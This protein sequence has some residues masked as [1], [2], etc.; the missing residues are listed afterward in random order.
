MTVNL[1]SRGLMLHTRAV[2][3]STCEIN[4]L[5]WLFMIASASGHA[6]FT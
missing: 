5:L 3:N 2:Q 1:Q 4:V 6:I